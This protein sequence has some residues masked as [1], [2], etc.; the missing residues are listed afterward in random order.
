MAPATP[1]LVH[2]RE[3]LLALA[4]RREELAERAAA[5]N[6]SHLHTLEAMRFELAEA[7]WRLA[8]LEASA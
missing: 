8:E 5:A 1:D 2:L 7:A 4:H 3:R 6:P